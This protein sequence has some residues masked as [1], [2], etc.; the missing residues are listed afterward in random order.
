[1]PRPRS[2]SLSSVIEEGKVG[3]PEHAD[4]HHPKPA[5]LPPPSQRKLKRANTVQGFFSK[6]NRQPSLL[7]FKTTA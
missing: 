1:M 6:I 4:L 7:A 2:E 3:M 5:A